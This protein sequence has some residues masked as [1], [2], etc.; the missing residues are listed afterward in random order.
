MFYYCINYIVR[1]RCKLT[2]VMIY[3]NSGII[4][5]NSNSCCGTFKSCHGIIAHVI[6]TSTNVTIY[7]NLCS[8]IHLLK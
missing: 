4:Y 6:Y 3:F 1:C 2:Q 5:T 7:I 8:G